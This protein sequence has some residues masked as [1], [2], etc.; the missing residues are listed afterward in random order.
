[1]N[2]EDVTYALRRLESYING[3]PEADFNKFLNRMPVYTQYIPPAWEYL[4]HTYKD[5]R[6]AIRLKVEVC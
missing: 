3:M 6:Q 1:M 4:K 2:K 5:E